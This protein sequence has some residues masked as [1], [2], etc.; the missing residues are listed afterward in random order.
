MRLEGLLPGAGLAAGAA[1]PPVSLSAPQPALAGPVHGERYGAAQ[2]LLTPANKHDIPDV[3]FSVVLILFFV[4]LLV[5]GYQIRASI[6]SYGPDS[7]PSAFTLDPGIRSAE[8][9]SGMKQHF[10]FT[11]CHWTL[12]NQAERGFFFYVG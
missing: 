5:I 3:F 4:S 1:L 2:R 12:R 11:V 10:E 9:L 6:Y 8:T 7:Q